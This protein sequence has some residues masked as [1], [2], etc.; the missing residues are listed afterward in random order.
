MRNLINLEDNLV[1]TNVAY[2]KAF[3]GMGKYALIAGA[4]YCTYHF[5]TGF[6]QQM[7]KEVAEARNG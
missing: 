7:H 6:F 4:F 1:P 5:M 3:R 2:R